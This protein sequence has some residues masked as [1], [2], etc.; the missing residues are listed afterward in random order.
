LLIITGGSQG[1]GKATIGKFVAEGWEAI[2]LSRKPCEIEDI[3]NIKI[4]FMSGDW[5]NQCLSQ[6][7]QTCQTADKV[8]L[9]H[10]AAACQLDTIQTVTEKNLTDM[11]HLNT[12]IPAV[13]T[14]ALLSCMPKHSSVIYIG[15]T[16]AEKAVPGCL[17]YITSK[18][19]VAGLMKATCQDLAGTDIYTCCICPGITDTDMLRERCGHDENILKMLCDINASKRLI[20]P[21]EIANVIYFAAN[22][23]VINGSVIHAHLGQI[24]K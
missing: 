11:L 4:N 10:N 8:A 6:L 14:Q 9:V 18:H 13:L 7:Q 19:A 22:H 1:I 16:L 24:E 2:N 20:Q 15:S 5:Q 3:T 12:V 17:S 23:A 21:E